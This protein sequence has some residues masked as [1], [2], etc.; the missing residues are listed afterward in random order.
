VGQSGGGVI[1]CGIGRRGD[2][3]SGLGV[4]HSVV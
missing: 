4:L 3:R 2:S 1:L